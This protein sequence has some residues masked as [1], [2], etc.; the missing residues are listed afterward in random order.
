MKEF[1]E[2]G[3][4]MLVES[5]RAD[6]WRQFFDTILAVEVE[7]VYKANK[8]DY[9]QQ[10]VPGTERSTSRVRRVASGENGETREG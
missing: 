6:M 10:S 8:E 2:T 7:P 4:A 9:E 3:G 5:E 1:S